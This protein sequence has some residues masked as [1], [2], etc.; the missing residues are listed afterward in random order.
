MS[1][2]FS[3]SSCNSDKYTPDTRSK[4]PRMTRSVSNTQNVDFTPS[5]TKHITFKTP[6]PVCVSPSGLHVQVVAEQ[7]KKKK[8]K[9]RSVYAQFMRDALR[10][11]RSHKD[12]RQ[13]LEHQ[14]MKGKLVVSKQR[15]QL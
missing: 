15:D 14:I 6:K 8:K 4:A 2:Q 7:K 10:P 5:T 9:K 11:K 1:A 12:R 3:D 13:E